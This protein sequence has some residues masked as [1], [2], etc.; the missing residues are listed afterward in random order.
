ME[1]QSSTRPDAAA[2]C[3]AIDELAAFERPSSSAGER[4]AAEWIAGRL[5]ELGCRVAVEQERAHGGYWWPL[6]LANL[7]AA[8][9]GLAARRSGGRGRG[10]ARGRGAPEGRA[11]AENPAAGGANAGRRSV[12]RVRA[13]A[14][15]RAT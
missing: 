7:L 6:G 4:R 5:S 1:T 9:G 11:G 3:A 14:T 12:R 13:R 8:A 2:W 15:E 10:L